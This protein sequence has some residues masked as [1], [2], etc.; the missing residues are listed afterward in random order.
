MGVSGKAVRISFASFI[1]SF[2]VK[3]ISSC[4]IESTSKGLHGL[5][6]VKSFVDNLTEVDDVNL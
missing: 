5:H 3:M 6:G 1:P 4:N 2:A